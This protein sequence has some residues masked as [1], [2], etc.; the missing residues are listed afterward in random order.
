MGAG[1][2]ACLGRYASSRSTLHISVIQYFACHPSAV[3]N[4]WE[5]ATQCN[6]G[7]AQ[8]LFQHGKL[9]WARLENLVKLAQEGSG[10][11]D[12]S[13]TV[14]DGARVVLLDD[15]LRRQLLLALTENDRLHLE[16]GLGV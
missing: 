7:C 14:R 16:V 15:D 3:S 10:G 9:Q 11:L 12:L 8:V 6:C 1:Q 13:D 4:N 2:I 5:A